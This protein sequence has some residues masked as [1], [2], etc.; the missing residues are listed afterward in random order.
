MIQ[1]IDLTM[2]R[3]CPSISTITAEL[4][5]QERQTRTPFWTSALP[6][7]QDFGATRRI[8]LQIHWFENPIR[9]VYRV[10]R[11]GWVPKHKATKKVVVCL[12]LLGSIHNWYLPL[13]WNNASIVRQGSIRCLE[14]QLVVNVRLV[15]FNL[16][17]D[18]RLA[19]NAF[20][21]SFNKQQGAILASLV[22]QE[23]S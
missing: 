1:S 21:D 22:Q 13:P 11:A 16:F 8:R 17:L 12:V 9:S 2:G 10:V 20:Q 14:M 3:C 6:A 18:N 15:N 5:P 4:V 19:K 23:H 7:P